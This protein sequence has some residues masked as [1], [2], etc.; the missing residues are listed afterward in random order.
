MSTDHDI[1]YGW[2][3]KS[4]D[5]KTDVELVSQG[6]ILIIIIIIT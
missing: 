5:G 4:E 2:Y 1:G 6:I 3:R